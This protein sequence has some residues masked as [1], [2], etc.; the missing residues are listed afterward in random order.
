MRH[1]LT[2]FLLTSVA[3]AGGLLGGTTVV[4]HAHASS[5]APYAGI[6]TLARA[7]ATIESQ[8]IEARATEDL[9]HMFEAMG[10]G[11][12]IDLERLAE[13]GVKLGEVLGRPLPGRYHLYHLGTQARRQR[14]SQSA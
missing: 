6:D 5:G 9:V 11:T 8:Y 13:T 4:H 10:H 3:F 7:L 1:T 14:S 2:A 12:G